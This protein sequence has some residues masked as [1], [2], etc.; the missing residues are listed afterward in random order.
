MAVFGAPVAHEDDPER[1]VR[2]ALAMQRAVRRVLDDER[3]GGAPVGPAHRHQHRRGGRRRP[4]RAGVHGHRRH[5]EH[6]RPAGRRGRGRRRLR[7]RADERRDPARG[8]R[9]GGCCRCGSRA[10]A[11]RSRRTSCSARSTRPAPGRAWATRG[12]SSAASPSWRWSRAGWPR[13]STAASPT[14]SSSPPR[15]A[16]ARPGSPPRPAGSPPGSTGRTSAAPRVLSVRC[17]A[18][19]ERWRLGP[20]ADLVR[21]AVGLPDQP[22]ASATRAVAEERLR[23]VAA[24][25]A[26]AHRAGRRG[27]T[28]SS[29]W[30]CSATPTRRR[31]RTRRG[32]ARSGSACPRPRRAPRPRRSRWP[33]CSRRWPPRRRW[34]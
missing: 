3:G 7:R 1:A 8:R 34:W 9:G 28:P 17:A 6:R 10:S 11:R 4:G 16:S 24:D 19:G 5:R 31:W 18:Y 13:S 15:R 27:C 32:S 29:C 2:A 33:S 20:L 23:R 14:C 21:V 22:N 25:G 30:R 12:R 26:A